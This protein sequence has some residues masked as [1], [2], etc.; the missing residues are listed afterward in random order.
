MKEISFV[1]FLTDFDYLK[2]TAMTIFISI[3]ESEEC[4]SFFL[5]S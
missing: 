5:L 3:F 1:E 4:F 2:N